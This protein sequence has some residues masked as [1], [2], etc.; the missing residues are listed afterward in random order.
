MTF[1]RISINICQ[2]G[3]LG[4]S[5]P[6]YDLGKP[7]GRK[8]TPDFSLKRGVKNHIHFDHFKGAKFCIHFRTDHLPAALY[9]PSFACTLEVPLYS[10]VLC[11]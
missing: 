8:N 9:S 10:S 3:Y 7:A 1:M 2:P 4:I 11:Y 6:V 5:V